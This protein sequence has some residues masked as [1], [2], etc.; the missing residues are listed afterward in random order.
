M[1]WVVPYPNKT[2]FLRQNSS[3]QRLWMS[4]SHMDW[5]GRR[6]GEVIPFAELCKEI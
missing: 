2:K 3:K 4:I 1:N 6:A 5:A